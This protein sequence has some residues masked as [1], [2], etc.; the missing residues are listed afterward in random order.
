MAKIRSAKREWWSKEKWC[1]LPRDVR[2]TYKGIWEVMADDEG[3]FQ[4]DARLIKADVWPLDDD[5][6]V[7]KI[8][9]W[10][11]QLAAVMVT[12]K[13]GDRVPA[14][15]LYSVDGVRYGFLAGFVKHQKI[16]H[17]LPSKI[18]APPVDFRKQT[19]TPPEINRDGPENFPPDTDT[20]LDRDLDLDLD[21]DPDAKPE[22]VVERD[23]VVR[24]VVAANK[25]ISEH[26]DPKRRQI[27]PLNVGSIAS[28]DATEKILAAGVPVEFAEAAITRIARVCEPN[29]KVN[30]LRYFTA[31]VIREWAERDGP[32]PNRPRTAS[33]FSPASDTTKAIIADMIAGKS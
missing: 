9:A 30:S 21:T 24:L 6:T 17:E 13:A 26:E 1:R 23:A 31:A 4:A 10:L 33:R 32:A 11:A 22:A 25:G 15:Q 14:I 5:I 27:D 29:G 18:P 19:G 7:K 3:R 20:D 16:S 12:S 8:E 2:S 28:K